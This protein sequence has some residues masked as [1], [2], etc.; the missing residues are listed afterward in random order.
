MV[1]GGFNRGGQQRGGGAAGNPGGY[2]GREAIDEKKYRKRSGNQARLAG[3][4]GRGKSLKAKIRRE[5]NM[6]G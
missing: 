4:G 2:A 5:K 3:A 6:D 1:A